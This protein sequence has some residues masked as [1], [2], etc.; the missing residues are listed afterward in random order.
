[1]S[2]AAA[3]FKAHVLPCSRA[4]TQQQHKQGSPASCYFLPC[5][6]APPLLALWKGEMPFIEAKAAA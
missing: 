5:L 3:R 4:A 2:L 6:A 1:M